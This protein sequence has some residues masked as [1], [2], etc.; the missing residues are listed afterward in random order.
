MQQKGLEPR[1]FKLKSAQLY[2][3]TEKIQVKINMPY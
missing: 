3:L 2:H 1:K